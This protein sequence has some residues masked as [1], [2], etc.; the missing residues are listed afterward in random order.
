MAVT[1]GLTSLIHS[2]TDP[3]QFILGAITGTV[4]FFLIFYFVEGR[5]N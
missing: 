5:K 3:I 1:M 4:L 2:S